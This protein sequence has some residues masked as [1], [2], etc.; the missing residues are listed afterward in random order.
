MVKKCEIYL[1]K[2]L[3]KRAAKGQTV[4]SQ[5]IR[6][7]PLPK[8]SLL[9]ETTALGSRTLPG[10]KQQGSWAQMTRMGFITEQL[11]SK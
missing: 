3:G 1:T 5:N 7:D 9:S 2:F 6:T 10:L 4:R 11:N 8:A